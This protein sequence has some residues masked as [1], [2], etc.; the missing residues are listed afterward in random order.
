MT[1]ERTP[2][3]LLRSEEGSHYFIPAADLSQYAVGDLPA[4][5][6]DGVATAAPQVHAFSVQRAAG[7]S[8]EVGAAFFPMPEG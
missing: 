3:V 5:V 2:G 4:E 6:R 1:D 7:A 8:D